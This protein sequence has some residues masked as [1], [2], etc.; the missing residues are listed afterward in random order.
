MAMMQAAQTHRMKSL[1]QMNGDFLVCLRKP[2]TSEYRSVCLSVFLT[3]PITS[4]DRSVCLSV[5][6]S[7]E[8]HHQ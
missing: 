3:K 2:I 7:E 4:E 6:L 5:C 1:A 8:A